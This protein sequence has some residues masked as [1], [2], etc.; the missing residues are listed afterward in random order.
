MPRKVT[1][2]SS[3]AS[4]RVRSRHS[5]AW[6]NA[7]LTRAKART[8]FS[9][10]FFSTRRPVIYTPRSGPRGD[11][12]QREGELPEVDADVVYYQT[13]RRASRRSRMSGPLNQD[14]AGP[15]E[16]AG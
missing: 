5:L 9:S 2:G 6:G 3:P 15:L 11:A 12:A 1:P 4:R 10:P 13:L 8:P 16:A 14:D 7:R